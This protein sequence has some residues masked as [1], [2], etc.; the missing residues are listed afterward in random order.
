MRK[1]VYYR[2]ISA[3]S[4]TDLTDK[5][6]QAIQEEGLQPFGDACV[7]GQNM[8]CFTQIVVKYEE[9]CQK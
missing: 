8:S 2:L 1:I 6:N 5:V 9:R 7:H 4:A 3:S